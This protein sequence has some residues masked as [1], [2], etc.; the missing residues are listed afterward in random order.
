[1]RTVGRECCLETG[2]LLQPRSAASPVCAAVPTTERPWTEAPG[3][4]VPDG[5]GSTIAYAPEQLLP[6]SHYK[7]P[8]LRGVRGP[9]KLHED[10]FARG[11]AGAG[12]TSVFTVAGE[13]VGGR[14]G[15]R[16]AG[17]P[18]AAVGPANLAQWGSRR[19]WSARARVWDTAVPYGPPCPSVGG[20]GL[21]QPPLRPGTSS[22]APWPTGP[23]RLS[24]SCFLTGLI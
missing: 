18:G 5:T 17:F 12:F 3:A 15:T 21:R 9:G 20:G 19:P 1:M 23:S 16:S 24:L 6:P 10:S 8:L 22:S 7:P 4:N 13:C 14:L 11:E 2:G